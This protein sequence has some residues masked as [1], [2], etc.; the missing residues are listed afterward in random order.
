MNLRHPYLYFSNED[1]PRLKALTREGDHAIIWKNILLTAE[2]HLDDRIPEQPPPGPARAFYDNGVTFDPEFLVVHNA[3]YENGYRVKYYGEL[4]AFAYLLSG[5]KR[6]LD[7]SKAWVL[8]HC[9]WSQWDETANRSDVQSSHALCGIAIVY[10]W[11]YD[12][13]SDEERQKIRSALIENCRLFRENWSRPLD[14]G[15]HFW[16]CYAA[17]GVG[18]LALLSEHPEA[19]EWVEF[20][21][22]RYKQLLPISFGEDGDYIDTVFFACYALRNAFFY[23]EALKRVRGINLTTTPVLS[24]VAHWFL[25]SLPPDRDAHPEQRFSPIDMVAYFRPVMMR[26]GSLFGDPYARWFL[27]ANGEEL[28]AAFAYPWWYDSTTN[29]DKPGR[30]FQGHWEFLSYDA[31][32]PANSPD[33]LPSARL[34]RDTGQVIM[35]SGWERDDV[36]LFFRSGPASGKDK[37][38]QNGILLYGYGE[39]LIDILL[40]PRST[41]TERGDYWT[42]I[43]FF[44]TTI[45]SNSLLVDGEGQTLT[46]PVWLMDPEISRAQ[47]K[48]GGKV[49]TFGKILH[50]ESRAEWDYALGEANKA[51]GGLLKTFKRHVVYLKPD[52]FILYDEIESANSAVPRRY[53]ILF[54]TLGEIV[55]QTDGIRIL[56]PRADLFVRVVE[57][58]KVEVEMNLTPIAQDGKRH[59][60]AM[61]HPVEKAPA[62]SLLAL[63]LPVRKGQQP[64]QPDVNVVTN[65]TKGLLVRHRG[66]EFQI[67]LH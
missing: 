30:S 61:I 54:H 48:S 43:H 13:L 15:N 66:R 16:V 8:N 18:A 29:G 67:S 46:H 17:L 42:H 10:D 24:R 34:F 52:C 11:L 59:P 47:W 3:Y 4:F 62:A 21:T 41:Y 5:D 19:E 26:L 64:L 6:F 14:L 44:Q 12:D 51:Y 25:H 53:D 45:G 28:G 9:S 36:W 63:L 20:V 50:F 33:E 39:R 60:F 58:R 32:V 31:N 38:D 57:P 7:R 2:S 56:Q 27:S 35:R 23:F 40:P 55:P 22:D 37:L 1:L 49:D 65:R